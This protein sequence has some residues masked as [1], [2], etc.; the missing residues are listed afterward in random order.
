MIM[1]RI[2]PKKKVSAEINQKN[3]EE[4]Q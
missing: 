1:P 4:E 3:K 2:S